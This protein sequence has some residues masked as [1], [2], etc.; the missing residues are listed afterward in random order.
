[1][2]DQ[3]WFVQLDV[4][5]DADSVAADAKTRL[6]ARWPGWEA[7]DADLETIQIDT[8]APIASDLH[9][10]LV[11]VTN[12]IFRDYGTKLVGLPYQAGVG[13]HTTVTFTLTDTDGHTIPAGSEIDI[14]GFAFATDNDTIVASGSSTAAAVPV[15]ATTVGEDANGLT[16]TT[17][18]PITSLAFVSNITVDTTTT[19]GV[20]ADD[21]V[22]YQNRLSQQLLLQAKTLVTT[23]DFELWA[24]N[25]VGIG[26]ALAVH[27]G[28]RAVQVTVTDADGEIVAAPIKTALLA[29]YANFRLVNTV[30]TLVDP[31]Y[32][33]INV[34][35]TV[36]AEPGFATADLQTRIAAALAELLSPANWGRPKFGDPGVSTGWITENTIRRNLIIDRI[37]D[38]EGVK[39]VHSVDI[40]GSAGTVDGTNQRSTVDFGGTVTGGTY[41]L[42]FQGQTTAAIQWNATGA[43]VVTALEAL[44]NVEPGDVAYVSGGPGPTDIVLEF[45]GQYARRAVTFT[46]TSSLTGTTPTVT[47]VNTTQVAVNGTGNLTM[48]GTVNLPRP[49][50]MTISV[51]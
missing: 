11:R 18:A 33:T 35:T 36:A 1:M 40:T 6:A 10:A 46:A 17:V 43:Q 3:Q 37:G 49:G 38:V 21:D 31:T 50:T 41:T 39:Y 24:L 42:T 22:D 26:R 45:R 27:L 44:S 29:D 16:G 25:T 4:D 9:E 32:T 20:D 8:L 47:T 48:P 51:I 34:T 30:V 2:T 12:A 13:A 5:E 7:R 23:R 14:D 28:D 19:G 15:T